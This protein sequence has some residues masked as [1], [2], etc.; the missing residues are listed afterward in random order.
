MTP[1]LHRTDV[2]PIEKQ[3]KPKAKK[4]RPVKPISEKRRA[5]FDLHDTLRRRVFERDGGCLLAG[6]TDRECAGRN[7]VHHRLK[8]S[9][10]GPWTMANLVCLCWFHNTD[11]EDRPAYYRDRW[12]WLVVRSGDAEFETLRRVG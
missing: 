8:A 9:A 6:E 12:P 10:G 7:T 3:G 1:D 4:R 11:I 5:A 2:Q